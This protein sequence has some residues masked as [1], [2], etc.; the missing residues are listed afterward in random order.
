MRDPSYLLVVPLN[1]SLSFVQNGRSGL[2]EVGEY[3]LLGQNNFYELSSL[4]GQQL[5]LLRIPLADLRGD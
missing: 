5:L 1:A 3:V 4:P 2:V